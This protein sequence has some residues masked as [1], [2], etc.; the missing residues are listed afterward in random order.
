ML[1]LILLLPRPWT[2][3]SKD[4]LDRWETD[5]GGWKRCAY[6]ASVERQLVT[7]R[8]AEI[9]PV[10]CDSEQREGSGFQGF[11]LRDGHLPPGDAS[12]VSTFEPRSMRSFSVSVLSS[13]IQ[14]PRSCR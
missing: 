6:A 13:S 12:Y 1:C 7:S 10:A 9:V 8:T 14:I 2:L 3:L 11:A 5:Q 4:T